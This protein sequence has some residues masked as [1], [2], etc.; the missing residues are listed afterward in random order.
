[1]NM[2][3]ETVMV[4]KMDGAA[5]IYVCKMPPHKASQ[6]DLHVD[7][8]SITSSIPQHQCFNPKNMAN[9]SLYFKAMAGLL[10]CNAS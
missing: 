8:H 6:L 1:M 9:K 2:M 10:F 4:T 5:N 7:Y 3:I